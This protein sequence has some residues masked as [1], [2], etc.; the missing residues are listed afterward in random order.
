MFTGLIAEIGTVREARPCAAGRRFLVAAPRTAS[1]L[2]IGESVACHGV[3]LTVE[4]VDAA[5]G[6]FGV[7]AVS[8]TL[9]RTTAGAWRRGQRLHLERAVTA[10]E[11]MGGHWVQG[12]V[13]GMARVA[14]AGR[15]RGGFELWLRLPGTLRRY[16]VSQGSIAVDG[17]SLTVAGVRGGLCGVTLVPETLQRTLLGLLRAG[18]RM[19]LEVDLVAK[20]VESLLTG[21][22]ALP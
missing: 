18:D 9:R 6:T 8:A 4:S 1:Q 7:A 19:N 22:W 17:V 10:D 11:R 2:G 14:R 5:A 21:R 15:G 13:D 20:Y 16:V 12:H 3:C